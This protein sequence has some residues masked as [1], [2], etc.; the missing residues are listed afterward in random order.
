VRGTVKTYTNPAASVPGQG[1][2]PCLGADTSGF[3]VAGATPT[4]TLSP[5]PAATPTPT[6][7]QAQTR[8]VRVGDDFFRDSV[9]GNNTTTISVGTKVEWEFE[10]SNS[11]TTTSGQC[12]TPSGMWSSSQMRSGNF[13]FTFNQP[14]TFPYFCQVHLSMM[15]GT[16]IVNP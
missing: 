13:D 3:A 9:S 5:S 14:G 1:T 12:C 4:P 8:T 7:G 2:S 6:P 15:T 16:V 11:H 10:A